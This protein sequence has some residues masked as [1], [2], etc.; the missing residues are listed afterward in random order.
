MSNDT[1]ILFPNREFQVKGETV[2]VRPFYFGE[3]PVVVK[4]LF[5]ILSTSGLSRMLKVKPDPKDPE[6][7]E[8][9]I[10]IPEDLMDVLTNVLTDASE[11]VMDLLAFGLKKE[12]SWFNDIDCDVGVEL[13]TAWF[14]GALNRGR[15][16]GRGSTASSARRWLYDAV[17]YIPRRCQLL[18]RRIQ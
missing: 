4:H 1:V 12:R 7:F 10:S 6:K 5:P 11:P 14:M 8:V 17:K 3:L 18:P 16:E 2:V 13:T 15:P 9:K